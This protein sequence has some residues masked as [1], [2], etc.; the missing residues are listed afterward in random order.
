[1]RALGRRATLAL[2]LVLFL[3]AAVE[4]IGVTTG[5]PF[6]RYIYTDRWWPT[7][8]LPDG[9]RFPLLLPFAWFLV[10]GAAALAVRVR[11]LPGAL[12]GGL[13]AAGVDL[14]MEPVMAGPLDYWRWLEPGPLPGGAP[15]LN[16][17]GWF[18][19]ASLAGAVLRALGSDA[20]EDVREPRIV[21]LGHLALTLGLGAIHLLG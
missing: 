11:G 8:P 4:L 12:L 15:I 2:A 21:L 14:F 17:V 9:G 1:M 18:A 16:F 10:A 19:T 5:L 20:V 13:L 7:V 6:G 3:G